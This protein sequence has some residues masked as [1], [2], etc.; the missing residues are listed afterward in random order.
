[1]KHGLV[2][3]PEDWKFGSYH[4][5]FKKQ[6]KYLKGMKYPFD[7]VKIFDMELYGVQ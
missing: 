3:K 4:Y 5:R 6:S 7:R 2:E 1:V